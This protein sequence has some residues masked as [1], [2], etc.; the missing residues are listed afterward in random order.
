MREGKEGA[1]GEGSLR[2]KEKGLKQEHLKEGKERKGG[3]G[4]GKGGLG[5]EKRG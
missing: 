1:E 3:K 5:K 2:K 4:E